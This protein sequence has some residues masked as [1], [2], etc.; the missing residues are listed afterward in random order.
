MK[1]EKTI[2]ETT[3]T[4]LNL[5][6]LK[7]FKLKLEED[8]GEV[9]HLNIDCPEPGIL[10]GSRGETIHSLQLIMSLIVFNKLGKWQRLVVNVGDYREKRAESLKKLALNIAQRVKFSGEEALMPF[11]SAAERRVV[12]LSLQDHPDVMT[13][14]RGEG[15]SR[16]LII[17]P[18]NKKK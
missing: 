11:L 1:V 14:S 12:H 10:I 4:L 18:K 15:E 8:E 9:I 6:G 2:K 16:R 7:D 13:E 17:K 3:T 5:L